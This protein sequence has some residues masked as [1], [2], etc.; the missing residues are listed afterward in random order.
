MKQQMSQPTLKTTE[1]A[2]ATAGLRAQTSVRAGGC[3]EWD[4]C[5][6]GFYRREIW[7]VPYCESC[8]GWW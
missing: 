1:H 7:G 4:E 5:P 6:Y 3:D 2:K 8:N